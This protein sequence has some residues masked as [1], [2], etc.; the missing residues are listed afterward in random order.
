MLSASHLSRCSPTCDV[1]IPIYN[2]LTHLRPCVESVLRYARQPYRLILVDDGSDKHT[3]AFLRDVAGEH[4]HVLLLRNRENVGFVRSCNRAMQASDAEYLILLNSDTIVTPRWLEKMVA[5]AESD[6]AIAAASPISN[7]CPHM[8]IKMLP[9]YTFFQ[10]AELVETLSDR[11]YPDVTTCEGF[12]LLLRRQA[13]DK[14]GMFDEV[15]GPGYGEESDFCMRAVS[16]GWR[17]VCADDTY[18][19]HKGRGTFGHGARRELYERNRQ[20]FRR[21]WGELYA[22]DF[23]EFRRRNPIGYLRNRIEQLRHPEWFP[24][25]GP[26]PPERF[27]L[28]QRLSKQVICAWLPKLSSRIERKPTRVTVAVTQRI[29]PVR[30]KAKCVG[31]TIL[32]MPKAAHRWARLGRARRKQ[33]P[34]R[35]GFLLPTMRPYGGVIS[36]IN[37]ANELVLAGAQVH[38]V[39]M[40]RYKGLDHR[41]CTEPIYCRDRE[42][43]PDLFPQVDIAVATQWETV[44]HILRVAE[45]QPG[46]KTFYFVQGYETVLVDQDDETQRQQV[47]DTYSA[48]KRKVAKTDYLCD[49]V[50]QHDPVVYKINPGMDLDNFYPRDVDQ[51]SRCRRVLAMARPNMPWRGFGTMCRVFGEVARLCPDVRFVLYGTDDLSDNEAQMSFP[52]ENSGVVSHRELP[53]LYSSCAIYCDFSQAHGFGRTGVE[54]MACGCACVLTESGG[55]SEYARDGWNALLCPPDDVPGLVASV[56]RLL[57]DPELRR[58]LA[59]NGLAS[60]QQYCDPV[61][62]HQMHDLFRQ[63]LK[64]EI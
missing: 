54:A 25:D 6:P 28:R 4:P 57:E 15:Y 56:V 18:I 19:Y 37:M 45:L 14:L 44:R 64:G 12:C 3:A 7:F 55:V 40:S 62:A 59:A 22:R 51:P 27:A 47:T 26:P 8:Q 35:V 39:T 38:I 10:M 41:L 11:T 58:K 46:V 42:R 5:C 32:D 17:T 63:A 16:R 1:A 60:V 43:I 50:R 2:G 9:G 20:I 30:R 36:V 61:A 29:P 21:R 52:F 49:L 13:L 23:D 24:F 53:A 33:R 34:M 48:I 31:R